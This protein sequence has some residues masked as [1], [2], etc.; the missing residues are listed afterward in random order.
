MNGL[1]RPL[2]INFFPNLNRW[3]LGPL[4]VGKLEFDGDPTWDFGGPFN[5]DSAT[6]DQIILMQVDFFQPV[7]HIRDISR[8]KGVLEQDIHVCTALSLQELDLF[9]AEFGMDTDR[10]CC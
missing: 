10:T 6:T 7:H 4:P 8:R 5:V 9:K 3:F 1:S 2:A